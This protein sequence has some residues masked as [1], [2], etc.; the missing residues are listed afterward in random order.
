MARPTLTTPEWGECRLR[1]SGRPTRSD[2]P[3][4]SGY[5][6]AEICGDRGIR[7]KRR[8]L[9]DGAAPVSSCRATS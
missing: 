8:F 3:E 1:Q 5:S 4:R 6:R 9:P 2:P 7:Q